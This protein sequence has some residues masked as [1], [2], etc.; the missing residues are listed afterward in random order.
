MNYTKLPTDQIQ[1]DHIFLSH[2]HSPDGGFHNLEEVE[3]ELFDGS[4]DD[5]STS[6]VRKSISTNKRLPR[7]KLSFSTEV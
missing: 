3:D 4:D 6:V 7:E 2:Y 5:D 1:V